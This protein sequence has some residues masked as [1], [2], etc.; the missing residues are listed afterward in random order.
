[1]HQVHPAAWVVKDISC[2]SRVHLP[3]I[4]PHRPFTRTSVASARRRYIEEIRVTYN[5][6]A[7][8]Q[9][10]RAP[11]DCDVLERSSSCACA[12]PEILH[13]ILGPRSDTTDTAISLASRAL[14]QSILDN[15]AD[16]YGTIWQV[17]C[18]QAYFA[19]SSTYSCVQ[20]KWNQSFVGI[21][22]ATSTPTPEPLTISRL[23]FSIPTGSRPLRAQ[24]PCRPSHLSRC[25]TRVRRHTPPCRP[26]HPSSRT[27]NL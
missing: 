24:R 25:P 26:H 3:S 10:C 19:S 20:S 27:P 1:M 23:C 14:Y 7:H 6:A 4:T 9:P 12:K 16:I 18:C 22:H 5:N 15:L 21:S 2:L 11:K 17:R 13:H 8:S